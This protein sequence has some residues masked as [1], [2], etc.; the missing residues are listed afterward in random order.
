MSRD[1][2]YDALKK[3]F[4]QVKGGGDW[5]RIPCPTCTPHNSRKFKRYVPRTGDYHLGEFLGEP[6]SSQH[7]DPM[8]QPCRTQGWWRLASPVSSFCVL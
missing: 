6:D 4:N 1:P 5:L 8:M 3:K 7:E 2:L